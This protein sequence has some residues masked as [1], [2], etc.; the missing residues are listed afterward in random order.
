MFEIMSR[1]TGD[2]NDTENALAR[3]KEAA[4]IFQDPRDQ[5]RCLW[6]VGKLH[7]QRSN[8][9]TIQ[10]TWIKHIYRLK[11]QSTKYDKIILIEAHTW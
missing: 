9:R 7:H 10:E 6:Q 4:A 3:L 2:P 11:R 1:G 8:V 5:A